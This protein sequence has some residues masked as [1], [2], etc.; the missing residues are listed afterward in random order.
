MT[1]LSHSIIFRILYGADVL[2]RTVDF[3]LE[4]SVAADKA[5]RFRCCQIVGAV[6]AEMRSEQ[7]RPMEL[8]DRVV[9]VLLPRLRD[10]V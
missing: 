8:A 2:I 7:E 6:W 9:E 1:T 5:V 10:K 4:R 3:L